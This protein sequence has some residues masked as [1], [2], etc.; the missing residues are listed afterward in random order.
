METDK[1]EVPHW[2]RRRVWLGLGAGIL[3]TL[4]ALFVAFISAGGGH[5]D[6]FWVKVLF[7][8][9]ILLRL[10]LPGG[11]MDQSLSTFDWLA[12][13]LPPCVQFSIYGVLIGA[14]ASSFKKAV[15][16]A[17]VIGIVH[18]LAVALCFCFAPKCFS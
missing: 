15:V 16:V 7:P 9:F 8:C 3:L 13:F 12:A 6:Y 14:F 5:G 17:V 18:A 4:P 1:M 2:A 10:I 11:P